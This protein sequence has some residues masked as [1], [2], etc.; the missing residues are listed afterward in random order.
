MGSYFNIVSVKHLNTSTNRTCNLVRSI[1]KCIRRYH[2]SAWLICGG[3]CFFSL[4]FFLSW[5][6]LFTKIFFEFLPFSDP[7]FPLF[8]IITRFVRGRWSIGCRAPYSREKVRED[9]SKRR[10][11]RAYNQHADGLT[12]HSHVYVIHVNTRAANP[13]A[14]KGGD[15]EIAGQRDSDT[16]SAK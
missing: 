14:V 6:F 16:H 1:R 13:D 5:F 8:F 12:A 7:F 10:D 11:A 9:T 3:R 2:C 15:C 4:Y